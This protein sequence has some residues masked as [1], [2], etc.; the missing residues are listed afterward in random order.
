MLDS[1]RDLIVKQGYA[2]TTMGQIADRAGV[3]VQTLYYTFRSKGMLL[4]EVIE[5]TAAGEENAPPVPERPWS[6]EMMSTDSG[7]R[8]LALAVEHGTDIYER[9]SPLWPALAAAAA[10]DPELER[11]WQS[12]GQGRRAAQGRIAARLH[13]LGELRDDVDVQRG[14]DIIVVLLGHDVFRGLV[15]D[16]HWPLTAYKAWLLRTLA[17]QLLAEA[18]IEPRACEGLSFADVMAQSL[19]S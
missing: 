9:V 12:I 17:Q 11:Y 16:A 2:A 15:R 10:A 14:T 19:K 1:A 13:Q 5:T 8:A 18:Q 6:L 3:A 4:R 7:Q